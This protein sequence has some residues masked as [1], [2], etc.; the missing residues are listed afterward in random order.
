MLED[1]GANAWASQWVGAS[2]GVSSF[3]PTKLGAIMHRIGTATV[4][5][6]Y[7]QD[8]APQRCVLNLF[9]ALGSD[10]FGRLDCPSHHRI[11]GQAGEV[12]V[13]SRHYYVRLSHSLSSAHNHLKR[14]LQP[15]VVRA[16]L[17]AS[18]PPYLFKKPRAKVPPLAP[19][20]PRPYRSL[21]ALITNSGP[22]TFF[23]GMHPSFV[24]A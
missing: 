11:P 5:Y 22:Y 10:E 14:F 3:P 4:W 21:P 13:P 17:E 19:R 24:S 15:L 9:C 18:H 16:S 20:P 6:A 8:P 12:F 1:H 23:P 7:L 2:H